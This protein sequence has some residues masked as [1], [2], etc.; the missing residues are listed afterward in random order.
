MIMTDI[1][2]FLTARLDE[3][4]AT[5]I[6]YVERR[7]KAKMSDQFSHGFM[8]A[9]TLQLILSPANAMDLRKFLAPYEYDAAIWLDADIASKR[10]ILEEHTHGP[11]ALQDARQDHD[12]GCHTCHVDTHCGEIMGFGWCDTVRHMATA[13]AGHADFDESWRPS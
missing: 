1:V 8:V 5:L 7:H 3:Q 4:A 12:F 2:A 11:A 10:K 9:D 13:Y 6:E